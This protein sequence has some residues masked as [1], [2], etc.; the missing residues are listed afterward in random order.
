MRRVNYL[1]FLP[2]KTYTGMR[3]T[4]RSYTK[5][6]IHLQNINKSNKPFGMISDPSGYH[7]GF[8]VKAC[9]HPKCFQTQ[10]TPETC[11]KG[12]NEEYTVY[13]GGVATHNLKGLKG[14]KISDTDANN[15]PKPQMITQET[16]LLPLEPNQYTLD[17]K[18]TSKF[19]EE[20][21]AK[22][23]HEQ[24]QEQTQIIESKT[25]KSK[26]KNIKN[27]KTK[28]KGKNMNNKKKSIKMQ[29]KT[30]KY[31]K[32]KSLNAQIKIKNNN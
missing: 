7:G 18:Y 24:V 2:K 26:N 30:E 29:N 22:I 14:R 32:N 15:Q 20:E 31:K 17:N 27:T 21:V 16:R 25:K 1:D 23:L 11:L 8:G 28:T 6:G 3:I 9:G 12:P 4:T 5:V 13:L 19:N 10:C